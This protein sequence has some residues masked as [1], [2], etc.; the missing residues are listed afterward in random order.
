MNFLVFDGEHNRKRQSVKTCSDITNNL[1]GMNLEGAS[2]GE[3]YGTDIFHI[4]SLVIA[5]HIPTSSIPYANKLLCFRR[6]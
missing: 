6:K 3:L 1:N 5:K 4:N 2:A